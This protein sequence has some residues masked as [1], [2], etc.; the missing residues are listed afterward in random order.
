MKVHYV[1][2]NKTVT[3]SLAGE[4]SLAEFVARFAAEFTSKNSVLPGFEL[5]SD[6]EERGTLAVA[7]APYGWALVH[8]SQDHL[9]QHCTQG[10][11]SDESVDVRWDEVTSVPKKWFVPKNQAMSAVEQWAQ[12]GTLSADVHWS[13]QCY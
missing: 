2:A 5:V 9:T 12:D 11:A 1:K 8:T 3:E 13:D 7:L 4:T 6:D 10:D